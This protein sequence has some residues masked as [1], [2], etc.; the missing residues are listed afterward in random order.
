MDIRAVIFPVVCGSR[1]GQLMKVIGV[2]C[3][4]EAHA[5]RS[6]PET[7]TSFVLIH[8]YAGMFHMISKVNQLS[9]A[10]ST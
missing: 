3:I 5:V 4:S 9:D 8:I 1:K 10:M 2:Y 6:F 7:F